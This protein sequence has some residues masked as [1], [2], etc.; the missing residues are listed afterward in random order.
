LLAAAA[1]VAVITSTP[2]VASNSTS[3]T[4]SY[5]VTARHTASASI[6]IASRSTFDVRITRPSRRADYVALEIAPTEGNDVLFYAYVDHNGLTM[7]GYHR[8][9]SGGSSDSFGASFGGGAIGGGP[10]AGAP[11]N[12]DLGVIT[13]PPGGYRV[14]VLV[15]EPTTVH[16]AADRAG[17]ARRVHIRATQSTDANGVSAHYSGGTAVDAF[18][19]SVAL[20]IP[21]HAHVAMLIAD[22]SWSGNSSVRYVEPCFG[23]EPAQVQCLGESAQFETEACVG[24]ALS[25]CAV[26]P[27]TDDGDSGEVLLAAEEAPPAG[28]GADL[29]TLVSGTVTHQALTAVVLP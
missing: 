7:T 12:V 24:S 5:L 26:E 17:N 25:Y 14:V 6:R 9:G 16:L 19:R 10:R 3:G 4:T 15:H 27:T 11:R 1:A 22:E 2:A 28:T 8:S 18:H 13:L 20:Q 29:Y 21:A 23:S